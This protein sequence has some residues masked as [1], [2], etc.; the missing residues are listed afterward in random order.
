[1][2]DVAANCII[3]EGMFLLLLCLASPILS[4]KSAYLHYTEDTTRAY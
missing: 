4:F 3:D 2:Q 1:M